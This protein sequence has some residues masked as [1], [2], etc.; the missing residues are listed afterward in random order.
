[1]QKESPRC[2]MVCDVCDVGCW[3]CFC[4]DK[5][6]S[7]K[8]LHL[9]V[10]SSFLSY[11]SV[12]KVKDAEPKR[13]IL[14]GWVERYQKSRMQ[15]HKMAFCSLRQ[16]K[17][18]R[19]FGFPITEALL[20]TQTIASHRCWQSTGF[21]T[22]RHEAA[23]FSHLPPSPY[24][25]SRR[26]LR[27]NPCVSFLRGSFSSTSTS[28]QRLQGE[29]II[30]NLFHQQE[31]G[32]EWVAESVGV[33]WLARRFV[34]ILATLLFCFLFIQVQG[35]HY[36]FPPT[37]LVSVNVTCE[38]EVRKTTFVL[39]DWLFSSIPSP[40]KRLSYFSFKHVP[41]PAVMWERTRLFWI[42]RLSKDTPL[43]SWK[44]LLKR[45]S[46]TGLSLSFTPIVSEVFLCAK[47]SWVL[48]GDG[49]YCQT[50]FCECTWIQ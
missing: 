6:W 32:L 10:W 17:C 26:I 43:Y 4:H 48:V 49:F 11:S 12:K 31:F 25:K 33:E 14:V 27:K 9:S 19:L 41:A 23:P 44:G 15:S 37:T 8:C 20:T 22:L 24:N 40:L 2:M 35:R 46:A 18:H 29:L 3:S 42:S 16:A 30:S 13:S 36:T 34:A 38:K 47:K 39:S 28:C 7:W 21:I 1:M 45:S 5:L 50:T